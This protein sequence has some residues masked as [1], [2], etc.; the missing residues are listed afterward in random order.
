[1]RWERSTEYAPTIASLVEK[2]DQVREKEMERIAG[3][4]NE[5]TPEQRAA[6]DHL[7]RRMVAKILHAPIRNAKELSN[8]KQGHI[9]LSALRELFEL[10]DDLESPDSD[11][12]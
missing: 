5:M 9:Y 2:A 7:A 10:D 4:L 6:I 3:R 11:A 8:S 1:M 12:R